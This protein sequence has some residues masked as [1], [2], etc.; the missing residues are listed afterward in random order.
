MFFQGLRC[1][2]QLSIC[3]SLN[4]KWPTLLNISKSNPSHPQ[5]GQGR[6]E[7]MG[8]VFVVFSTFWTAKLN[9]LMCNLSHAG[10]RN[11]F[12]TVVSIYNSRGT[13]IWYFQSQHTQLNHILVISNLHASFKLPSTYDCINYA[14]DVWSWGIGHNGSWV[15][16][17]QRVEETLAS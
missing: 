7:R 6:G 1:R 13:N 3:W 14:F 10:D 2:W 17:R 12:Q 5:A 8:R 9:V 11:T 15:E 16:G 4:S